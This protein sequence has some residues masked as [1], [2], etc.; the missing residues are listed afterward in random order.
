[1][2]AL[3][4]LEFKNI[5]PEVFKLIDESKIKYTSKAY[6]WSDN[7]LLIYPEEISKYMFYMCVNREGLIN[8]DKRF[9]Y[10]IKPFTF[11]TVQCNP[12]KVSLDDPRII[13]YK[14]PFIEYKQVCSV[15]GCE[16]VIVKGNKCRDCWDEIGSLM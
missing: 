15:K 11:V 3:T 13:K 2:K 10:L 1:M 8:Y 6:G 4:H 5:C 14:D 7:T 9:I 16:D 12:F